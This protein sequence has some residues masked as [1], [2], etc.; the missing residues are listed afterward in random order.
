MV[1]AV[2]TRRVMQ[3]VFSQ[4]FDAF[5]ATGM[6]VCALLHASAV[7]AAAADVH[8]VDLCLE[9]RRDVDDLGVGGH[10]VKL[11]VARPLSLTKHP[12]NTS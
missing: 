1:P 3:G 10:G 8:W 11:V 5:D 2:A 4:L 12:S 6:C 9:A 7:A